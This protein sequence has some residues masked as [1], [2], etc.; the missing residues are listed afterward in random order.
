MFECVYVFLLCTELFVWDA[1]STVAWEQWTAPASAHALA[2]SLLCLKVCMREHHCWTDSFTHCVVHRINLQSNWRTGVHHLSSCTRRVRP[3]RLHM[4]WVNTRLWLAV[5]SPLIPHIRHPLYSSIETVC[6]FPL[7]LNKCVEIKIWIFYL[8][9]WVQSF[10]ASSSEHN[11][12]ANMHAG[13]RKYTP[14]PV[15]KHTVK[16]KQNT[17]F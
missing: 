1:S 5:G 4:L 15:V 7:I 11:R 16:L 6:S 10:T 2:L 13:C 12:M 9:H 14:S 3:D 8:Q 17:S